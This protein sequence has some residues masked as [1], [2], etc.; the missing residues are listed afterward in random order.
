MPWNSFF[1]RTITQWNSLASSV[2]DAKTAEGSKPVW[3]RLGVRGQRYASSQYQFLSAEVDTAVL[4]SVLRYSI[5]QLFL[6]LNLCYSTN[7]KKK[8]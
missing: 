6:Y 1:P 5:K 3:Y 2:V 4:T 8:F 7:S